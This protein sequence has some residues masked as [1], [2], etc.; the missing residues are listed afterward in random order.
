MSQA[1]EVRDAGGMTW[2]ERTFKIL[3]AIDPHLALPASI[4]DIVCH[5]VGVL[6]HSVIVA[7][8][9][10]VERRCETCA[11]WES[12]ETMGGPGPYYKPT[13]GDWGYGWCRGTPVRC[14]K[15]KASS[16]LQWQPR[17]AGE[18]ED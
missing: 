2:E 5:H 12:A 8:Q 14:Q 3:K 1:G 17:A 16:C 15:Y 4:N 9:V 7:S 11:G 13:H 18:Q 6:W 10:S